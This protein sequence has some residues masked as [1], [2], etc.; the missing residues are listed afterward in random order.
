MAISKQEMAAR[1]RS[2]E[3][4]LPKGWNVLT[5]NDPYIEAR[6]DRNR[7]GNA[8]RDQQASG[9]RDDVFRSRRRCQVCCGHGSLREKRRVAFARP[10]YELAGEVPLDEHLRDDILPTGHQR[11][12]AEGQDPA[13]RELRQ[14]QDMDGLR[15]EQSFPRSR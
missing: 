4:V 6:Y 7:L 15:Q 9:S 3:P 13:D 5:P 12:V 2:L 10:A 14:S 11:T 1:F 8:D